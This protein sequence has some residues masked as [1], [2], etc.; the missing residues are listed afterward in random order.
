MAG[1]VVNDWVWRDATLLSSMGM[2]LSLALSTVCLCAVLGW[3][4]GWIVALG[5][6]RPQER[7][8]WT[9]ALAWPFV[10]PGSVAALRLLPW[11][12]RLGWS[13]SAV[14]VVAVMT[15][16]NAPYVALRIAQS[17]LQVDPRL[18]EQAAV[19]GGG[20]AARLRWI[21]WPALWP[22]F[23]SAL[24]EVYL[25]CLGALSIVMLV[26]GG[27]PVE[28]VEVTLFHRLHG[29]GLD[30]WGSVAAGWISIALA[31]PAVA[32]L[33]WSVQSRQNLFLSPENS[34]P[35]MSGAPK[36]RALGWLLLT[37]M[38]VPWLIPE[39]KL[40]ASSESARE[41]FASGVFS[42]IVSGFVASAVVVFA[43]LWARRIRKERQLKFLAA[44]TAVGSAVPPM[45]IA[46]VLV[47]VHLALGRDPFEYSRVLLVLALFF[48]FLPF[49]LRSLIWLQAT[50]QE[51]LLEAAAVS[52]ARPFNAWV[53]VEWPRWRPTVLTVFGLLFV[54]ILGESSLSWLFASTDGGTPWIT[55]LLARWAGQYRMA[56]VRLGT[57][58]MLGLSA[59]TFFWWGGR[60]L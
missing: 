21:L 26:G 7:R 56:E 60:K 5:M 2:T 33:T 59:V 34:A 25:A 41:F 9:V 24:A 16:M 20:A 45:L 50:R 57:T 14:A 3:G 42:A 15:G 39:G 12:D 22:T 43:V 31:S 47:M 30:I 52:G 10:L 19:M 1:V 49:A 23:V 38:L 46:L 29:G 8:F 13:Y 54:W 18:L 4:L 51:A 48:C 32:V 53:V 35:F 11:L 17:R 37:V 55:A 6:P 58:V 28:T 36:W 40:A 27:P 44:A